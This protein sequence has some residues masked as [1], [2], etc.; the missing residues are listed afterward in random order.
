[1]TPLET[2]YL[3]AFRQRIGGVVTQ[4]TITTKLRTR[5]CN[6]NQLPE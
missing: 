3:S 4:T 1:M 5:F 6:A 2:E